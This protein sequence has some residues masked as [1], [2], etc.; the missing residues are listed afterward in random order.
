MGWKDTREARRVVV[1]ALPFLVGSTETIVATM[2]SDP[3]ADVHEGLRDVVSFLKRHGVT[4]RGEVIRDS[5][6]GERL[7]EFASSV[8]ADLI[9]SG[10]YG[11]SR[12]RQWVFGGVTRTLLNKTGFHRLMSY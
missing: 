4:A 3:D 7:V 1:D 12:I 6:S 11:H 8:H 10:A 2:D 5:E 9:V